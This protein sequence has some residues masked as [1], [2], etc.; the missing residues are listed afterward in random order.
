MKVGDLSSLLVDCEGFIQA[1]V[2]LALFFEQHDADATALIRA[3]A[4]GVTTRLCGPL[5]KLVCDLERDG[6]GKLEKTRTKIQGELKRAQDALVK[7]TTLA[8]NT[9]KYSEHLPS[10]LTGNVDMIIA[11][12]WEG[13]EQAN[14]RTA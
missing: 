14:T 10:A 3:Y 11:M 8:P 2:S 9:F 4:T 7:H 1:F 13:D 6:A 5:M 12:E